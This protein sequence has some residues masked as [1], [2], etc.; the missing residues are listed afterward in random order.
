[1]GSGR[2]VADHYCG[3]LENS[4]NGQEKWRVQHL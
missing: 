1:V 3:C 2:A 4:G